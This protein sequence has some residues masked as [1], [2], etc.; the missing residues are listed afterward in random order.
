M[1]FLDRFHIGDSRVGNSMGQ[2]SAA[3]L[4]TGLFNSQPDFLR[5]RV[6]VDEHHPCELHKLDGTFLRE[7]LC[8]V[9]G[10][11]AIKANSMC[12]LLQIFGYS[13]FVKKLVDALFQL[14]RFDVR[15][16]CLQSDFET[17][18]EHRCGSGR[19]ADRKTRDPFLK[20]T[21]C[22]WR[23]VVR[24]LN[25]LGSGQDLEYR[26]VSHCR[27]ISRELTQIGNYRMRQHIDSLPAGGADTKRIP[28]MLLRWVLVGVRNIESGIACAAMRAVVNEGR[29]GLRL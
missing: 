25:F 10:V 28:L 12:P 4:F 5:K 19:F 14:P 18:A 1:T 23:N 6:Q 21:I 26:D 29:H 16:M 20:R 27:Q 2:G 15:A 11:V 7:F 3:Q 9:E 8:F 13:T 17:A 24:R 22:G